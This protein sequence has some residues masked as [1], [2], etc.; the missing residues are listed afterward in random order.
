MN[1]CHFHTGLMVIKPDMKVYLDMTQKLLHVGSYDGADQG[2]LS[3]Y[4]KDCFY[5]PVF[6]PESGPSEDALNTMH[7]AYNQHALYF[8]GDA[9]GLFTHYGCSGFE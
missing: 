5:A 7:I 1:P 9:Q 3:A 4:F 6:D 2:F 8:L